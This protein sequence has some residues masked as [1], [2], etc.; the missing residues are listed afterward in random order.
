MAI[1]TLFLLISE[2]IRSLQ[3]PKMTI[4]LAINKIIMNQNL[5]LW[6]GEIIDSIPISKLI[7]HT[8]VLIRQ[9]TDKIKPETYS[10]TE[11]NT[12]GSLQTHNHKLAVVT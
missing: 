7:K 8:S 3:F 4:N 11:F 2:R 9:E 10:L 12:E 5:V 1:L 6:T